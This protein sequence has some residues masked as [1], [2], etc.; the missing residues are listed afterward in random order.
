MHTRL[1][2]ILRG[3][4]IPFYVHCNTFSNSQF[5]KT[6]KIGAN[7]P[8]NCTV[9]IFTYNNLCLIF[10]F[11]CSTAQMFSLHSRVMQQRRMV[12]RLMNFSNKRVS[13]GNVFDRER[14]DVTT[15]MKRW[16]ITTIFI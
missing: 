10:N 12:M 1:S 14:Y 4:I 16:K 8:H 3:K 11:L 15:T 2:H 7:F 13:S 6:V 9:Y 5:F